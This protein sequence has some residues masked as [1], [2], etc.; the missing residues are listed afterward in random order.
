MAAIGDDQWADENKAAHDAPVENAE[1]SR[2]NAP[3]L[4]HPRPRGSATY[5]QED[6]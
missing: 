2:E 6:S 5:D 4:R 3:D 1:S